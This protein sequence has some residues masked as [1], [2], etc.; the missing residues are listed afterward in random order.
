MTAGTCGFIT[1]LTFVGC[2]TFS[3]ISS[4]SQQP[5]LGIFDSQADVGQVKHPGSVT[6]DASRQEY[7]VTGSGTNMWLGTD[8]FHLV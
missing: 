1:A 2:L 5:T 3:T 4:H 7:T 8:E 6:Y